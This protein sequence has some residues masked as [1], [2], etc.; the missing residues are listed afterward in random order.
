MRVNGLTSGEFDLMTTSNSLSI[1]DLQQK[2]KDGE[3]NVIASDVADAHDVARNAVLSQ[4][5]R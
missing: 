5:L 3:I 1:V 4:K 2:A